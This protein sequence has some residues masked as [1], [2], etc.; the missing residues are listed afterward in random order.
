MKQKT[1]K[2]KKPRTNT[3]H[4]SSQ[5][6]PRVVVSF[7]SRWPVRVLDLP[8]FATPIILFIS[9]QGV[10]VSIY[11][12]F[13]FVST[14]TFMVHRVCYL[15]TNNELKL[16]RVCLLLWNRL[17]S[18]LETGLLG[19]PFHRRTGNHIEG[20]HHTARALTRKLRSLYLD[21]FVP[22]LSNSQPSV[23]GPFSAKVEDRSPNCQLVLSFLF[24]SVKIS[25]SFSAHHA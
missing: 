9:S 24:S 12:F 20:Y 22:G 13:P 5:D 18:R 15:S 19:L 4:R 2:K 7:S 6:R 21:A 10:L 14:D 1:F 11:L 25:L 16:S 8:R 17:R 23:E 3:R